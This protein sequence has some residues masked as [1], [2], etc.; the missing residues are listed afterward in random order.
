VVLRNLADRA[1]GA[2]ERSNH[3]R[4]G[5][6]AHA[7]AAIGLRHSDGEQ[8]RIGEKVHLLVRENAL[9]IARG[10]AFRKLCGNLLSDRKRLRV[11]A[12]SARW[13]CAQGRRPKIS[14]LVFDCRECSGHA[15]RVSVIKA[16]SAPGVARGRDAVEEVVADM[17]IF[18]PHRIVQ[19]VGARIAPM[20]VEIVLAKG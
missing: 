13:P 1:V 12:D 4:H 11:V 19:R 10:G 16:T 5:S 9:A 2:R 15:R 17:E 14:D 18:P 3:T 20:A 6:R 7:G 8:S